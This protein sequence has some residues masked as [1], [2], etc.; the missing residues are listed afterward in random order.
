MHRVLSTCSGSSNPL[1]RFYILF[2]FQKVSSQ[3]VDL[4]VNEAANR[5]D[6]NFLIL[7]ELRHDILS[8]F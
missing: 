8:Y 1:I 5:D 2:L 3:A 4:Y 7:K 6:F